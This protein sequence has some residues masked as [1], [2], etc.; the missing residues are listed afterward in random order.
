M[1]HH[2]VL[3]GIERITTRRKASEQRT[4]ATTEE[5]G[6]LRRRGIVRQLRGEG[7]ALA[8]TPILPVSRLMYR[9]PTSDNLSNRSSRQRAIHADPTRPRTASAR[10]DSLTRGRR[11]ACRAEWMKFSTWRR[12]EMLC[13]RRV[14]SV[15]RFEQGGVRESLIPCRGSAEVVCVSVCARMSAAR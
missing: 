10:R 4:T 14:R 15:R 11:V 2:T 12:M 7:R 8:L 1:R 5:E 9:S 6:G 3:T 13:E